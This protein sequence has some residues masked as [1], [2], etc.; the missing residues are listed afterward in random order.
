VRSS[1]DAF[2]S[3]AKCSLTASGYGE[4]RVNWKVSGRGVTCGH[5]SEPR[6]HPARFASIALWWYPVGD[7]RSA[8]HVNGTPTFIW[9]SNMSAGPHCSPGAIDTTPR[10]T[11]PIVSSSASSSARSANRLGTGLP[12]IPRCGNAKLVAKPAAPASIASR[13]TCCIAA[14]SSAVAVRS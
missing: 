2:C 5:T 4:S 1:I 10:P 7:V 8:P 3:A 12:S 11:S 9:R 13:S 14:I 6:S